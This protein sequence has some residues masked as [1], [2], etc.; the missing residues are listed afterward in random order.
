MENLNPSEII[1]KLQETD[2]SEKEK[3]TLISQ[4]KSLLEKEKEKNPQ[5][6]V[7]FIEELN[8]IVSELTKDIKEFNQGVKEERLKLSIR[9]SF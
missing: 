1:Q 5:E 6:Y 3:V 7:R 9:D 4:L 8:S 2:L